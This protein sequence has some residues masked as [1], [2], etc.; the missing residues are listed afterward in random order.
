[1]GNGVPVAAALACAAGV[2]VG[3]R[4]GSIAP[5][6]TAAAL[7]AVAMALGAWFDGRQRAALV[8][9]VVALALGGAADAAWRV[10]AGAERLLPTLA[11]ERAHVEVCGSVVERRPR[12]VTFEVDR[13]VADE[14]VWR[15]SEPVRAGGEEA[16]SLDP[17]RS[18]CLQGSLAPGRPGR[19]EPPFLAVSDAAPGAVGSWMRL[20]A[21]AVRER[22]SDAA[23]RVL[24]P[25]QAGL[26][27]GMTE[28]DTRLV[29]EPTM[30]A[31]RTTGLAHLVAVS[32][33]NVAVVLAIVL[34]AVR[35]IVPRGR[36]LR[37]L[38]AAPPLVFFAFLTALEPSV[39]RAVVSAGV[40]LA[41]TA[42]GRTADGIRIAAAAF[43]VLVLASP[44]LLER[45][46]FQLSFAATGGLVLWAG[47]LAERFLTLMPRRGRLAEAAALA[48]AATLAAQAAVA[49]L[50]ALHFGRLPAVGGLAN[51]LV[52]PVV[53]IVMVGGLAALA[54]ASVWEGFQWA[55][56]LLRL[57]LDAVLLTA[58]SFAGMPGSSIGADV[59]VGGAIVAALAALASRRVRVPALGLVCVLVAASA[60]LGT[61]G[62]IACDGS[63][64]RALDVGQGTA[65]L[66]RDG[67]HAVLFDG[68]PSGGGLVDELDRA[69]VRSLDAIVASHP[70]ADHIEGFVDVLDRRRVGIAIGP[71]TIG[72]GVGAAVVAASERAGVPVEIA[73]AGRNYRFGTIAVDV[74]APEPGPPPDEEDDD[75]V[76]ALGLVARAT[77]GSTTVLLP[78]DLGAREQSAL[79]G[80]GLAAD[81][82]VAPHHGSADLE[83]D[84]VVDVG[85]ALT[86]VTVG[87]DNRYGHPTASALI[88]Y[89]AQG[90]VFRTDTQGSVVVCEGD[91]ELEVTTE[92]DPHRVEPGRVPRAGDGERPPVARARGRRGAH[93]GRERRRSGWARR[94]ARGDVT[95]RV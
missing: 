90:E 95:V 46:G 63:E 82:L 42:T 60:G 94:S 7:V 43:I 16:E 81:V 38:A 76:N 8:V 13:V 26:L 86:L 68:G 25:V 28:G 17:G 53:P 22:F 35:V 9:A 19:D 52:A 44:D 87:R 5:E 20:S 30:E 49:P 15:V 88:A 65:V 2:S 59:L 58:R 78:G 21:F 14:S 51:L 41:V 12:S 36:W 91:G 72:W 64:V 33:S 75:A 73:D 3:L 55:P 47:P 48:A 56:L 69:G 32:G 29:D 89:E 50:L 92:R 85:A 27:L 57:P 31:F 45:P 39:L 10:H 74:L 66:V 77:V 71:A 34:V 11:A 37:A 18:A 54:A 4:T 67:P 40:V 70:H 80:R 84:F 62:R 79:I 6:L 61:A 83:P 93:L 1:M 23:E 24:P